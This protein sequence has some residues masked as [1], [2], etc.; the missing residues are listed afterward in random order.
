V[1][2]D[3]LRTRVL[4]HDHGATGRFV[5]VALG[6]ALERGARG[7]QHGDCEL[8][9][10]VDGVGLLGLAHL[11]QVVMVSLGQSGDRGF[12][13]RL[14]E[15]VLGS[16]HKV[17]Y[18]AM[19]PVT[20]SITIDRPREEIYAVLEDLMNHESFTDHFLTDFQRTETGVRAKG[21]GGWMEFTPVESSPDRIVEEGRSGRGGR[22]RTLGIYE[23]KPRNGSTVVSF[24]NE[25]V[26]PAGV[27]DRLMAPVIRAYLRKQNARAL[28]RLK[29]QMEAR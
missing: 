7:G 2:R 18:G 15:Q 26:E 3:L 10:V 28:E 20:V 9:P 17:Q 14:G 23:L 27:G 29:E 22:R 16:R 13:R 19:K 21:S 11:R 24:T 4:E 6:R 8:A 12:Q 25:F 1:D 5:S